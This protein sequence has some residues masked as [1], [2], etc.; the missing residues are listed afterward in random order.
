[1]KNLNKKDIT[2][3]LQTN[4]QINQTTKSPKISEFD[5]LQKF[6]KKIQ[7]VYQIKCALITNALSH[8]PQIIQ[9]LTTEGMLTVEQTGTE[10]M[11][12]EQMATEQMATITVEMAM[13]HGGNSNRRRE[14]EPQPPQPPMPPTPPP[15][16][17]PAPP[18][19]QPAP[20]PND[21]VVSPFSSKY[22]FNNNHK[23]HHS[24]Y[25]LPSYY[26]NITMRKI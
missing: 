21:Q 5:D 20:N 24:S 12:M 6:V 4:K 7:I 11:A 1:M 19:P 3:F 14:I 2:R 18:T 13:E 9:T 25:L 23:N 17:R 10:Q 16:P 15:Q 8:Y 22:R 26:S